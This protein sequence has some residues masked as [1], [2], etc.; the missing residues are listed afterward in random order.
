M[1]TPESHREY[2][3]KKDYPLGVLVR[4]PGLTQEESHVVSRY[5]YWMEALDKGH[6]QPCT[7]EQKAFVS[8]CRG[9][10]EPSTVF[11]TAWWKLLS[12]RKFEKGGWLN[13]EGRNNQIYGTTFGH[14]GDW[15]SSDQR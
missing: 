3:K 1:K 14:D 8:V 15:W 4:P 12:R 11:E 9:E 6:I 13:P 10:R 5:G 7:D 2:L